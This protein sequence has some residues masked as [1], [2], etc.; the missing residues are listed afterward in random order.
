MKPSSLTK[1]FWDG[2]AEK[3]LLLQYD[4]AAKRWQFYPRP[5]SL[6]NI[7]NPLQWKESAGRGT[8]V[9]FTVCHSPAKGFEAEVPY[10]VGIVRLDEG[11]RIFARLVN[12]QAK[13]LKTGMRMRAA[14]TETNPERLPL[15]FEPD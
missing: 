15:Q 6:F 13:D 11:V 14:W 4:A 1:P 10:V 7:K 3:R 8:L 5:V 9:A 2:A 12:V